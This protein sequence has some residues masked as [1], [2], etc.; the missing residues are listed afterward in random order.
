MRARTRPLAG[1]TD[2]GPLVSEA[3]RAG[4]HRQV[5]RA[6]ADGARVLTGGELPSGAGFFYPATILA[7]L[8]ETSAVRREELF[9]P[10]AILL[11][12]RDRD[13]ALKLANETPFGLGSSI[14]TDDQDEA[15]FFNRTIEAGMTFVNTAVASDPHLPFGGVKRSGFGRE[16]G[17][18]GLREFTNIKT[19]VTA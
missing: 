19:V 6:V 5:T 9:G 11:R 3:V 8:P 4:L 1:E 16:F 17:V 12:A 13:D 15:A 10:V 14:W 7:D 18:Y 2:L